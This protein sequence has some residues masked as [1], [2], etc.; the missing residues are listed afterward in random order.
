MLVS[1]RHPKP[2]V[3]VL[4]VTGAMHCPDSVVKYDTMDGVWSAA[5]EISETEADLRW[6]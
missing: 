1:V 4:S 3:F 6:M 5:R 2:D